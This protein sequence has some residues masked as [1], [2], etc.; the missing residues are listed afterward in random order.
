MCIA[1]RAIYGASRGVSI[2]DPDVLTL[3]R[4]SGHRTDATFE[5]YNITDEGDLRNAMAKTETFVATLPPGGQSTDGG[6]SLPKAAGGESTVYGVLVAEAGGS[7]THRPRL[8]PRA[9]RL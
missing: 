4:I 8:S 2:E 6:G 9:G 3:K 1:A 5:R 7:R